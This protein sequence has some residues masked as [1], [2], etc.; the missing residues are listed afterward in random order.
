MKIIN[1]EICPGC[2][3]RVRLPY[4]TSFK[5]NGKRKVYLCPACGMKFAVWCEH[6]P[7]TEV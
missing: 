3:A 7:K 6:K 1:S 5:T 2:D 4:I